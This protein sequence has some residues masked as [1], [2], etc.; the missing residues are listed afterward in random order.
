MRKKISLKLFP[1]QAAD[2]NVLKENIA[3]F[4]RVGTGSVSG[5]NIIKKSIDARS[6]QPYV[7]IT[8]DVFINEPFVNNH[9]NKIF[10]QDVHK[11]SKTVLIVGAGP[12]GLFAALK[13]LQH[14]IKPIII[15]RGKDVRSR[16][17]DLALLNKEG[18][19]NT[20]S[21]YCF[22]E[23][24]A[25]T[26]SDGKLYTRSNKRGNV[27]SILNMFVQFGAD[28]KI[29]YESHPHIGTNKL[30]QI[31]TA[32]RKQI[33][34][35][36]GKILFEKK[37]VDF[38]IDD[39]NI[40]SVITADSEVLKAGAYILATGHSARDIFLLLYKKKIL[41]EQ[42]PFALGVRVEHP[43]HIIDS[44]QY[45]CPVR[46]NYLPPASYSL[47]EQVN[48]K[49]V[50]S[51][52]MCPG[53]II[54][55]ASTANEEL[56]VNGWSPSKRNNPFANSGIVAEVKNQDLQDYK[57][58]DEKKKD[59][60]DALLGM[61]FQKSVEHKAYKAGGGNFVAP[62]QRMIDF[63]NN[64]TSASLPDCSYVPG[65]NSADLKMV[66]P[67]FIHKTLQQ[68]FKD[69]GKKMRGYFTN[70]AVVVAAESR[71]SSPVRIPRDEKKLCHPQIEN[72]YPCGEGAGYAGGIV[73]AAMDG[74]KIA[75][76]I[77][78]KLNAIVE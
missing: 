65:I 47:A 15:E 35:C 17:R 21:N 25:G 40:Q 24:G 16:R 62:A 33:E 20:E 37:L 43:Q 72:L 68:A 50:F 6:K 8:A 73:S 56:V 2:N 77:A 74:E 38:K 71:T 22:G 46:D 64:K 51:F 7:N 53:G 57:D 13:L 12:C 54:A 28:E 31:I 45:H 34:D 42:K 63:V 48:D 52:C 36:G 58:Y 5:F 26:Y 60:P 30:P 59:I 55:P 67:S 32:M 61:Y 70:D 27:Q 76:L 18:K 78:E 41:I 39:N 29:L 23:G 49:G 3:M 75:V 1:H 69:F 10:F 66:L 19:I 4:L 44:I 11:N 14:G 9:V